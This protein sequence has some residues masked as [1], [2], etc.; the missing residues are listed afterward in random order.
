[1]SK[2]VNQPVLV[3]TDKKAVP[4]RFFWYKRWFSVKDVLE[5]WKD[6]GRWWD[7]EREKVFFRLQVKEGGVYELFSD[8]AQNQWRLYKVYD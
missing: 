8:I 2:V 5:Q 4:R 3:V 7:G 1:V 6:T